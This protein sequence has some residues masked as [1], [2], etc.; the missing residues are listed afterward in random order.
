VHTKAM[1]VPNSKHQTLEAQYEP[2][3]YK[4]KKKKVKAI[5]LQE[6]CSLGNKSVRRLA[7]A[8]PIVFSR[9]YREITRNGEETFEFRM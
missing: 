6:L 7:A 8:E 4:T 9:L 5:A 3:E 2:N 1:R